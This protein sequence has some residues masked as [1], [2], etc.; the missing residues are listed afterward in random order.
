MSST[1]NYNCSDSI[2]LKSRALVLL[3]QAILFNVTYTSTNW[4][5]EYNQVEASFITSLDLMMPFIPWMILPYLS[6]AVFFLLAFYLCKHRR[7]FYQLNQSLLIATLV[8]GYFFYF[9]P[10]YFGPYATG[11]ATVIG[12]PWD[13]LFGMLRT[14]D[15]PYNQMPSLHIIYG[16]IL[17]F[18]LMQITKPITKVVVSVGIFTLLISTLLTHQ[19]RIIDVITGLVFAVVIL[20]FTKQCRFSAST[21]FYFGLSAACLLIGLL[22]LET[23]F[24]LFALLAYLSLGFAIVTLAYGQHNA[25]LLGKRQ[26]GKIHV[27]FWLI[28]FPYIAIYWLMWRIYSKQQK[29]QVF[30]WLKIGARPSNL[31]ALAGMTHII[32]LGAELPVKNNLSADIDYIGLPLLDL[33]PIKVNEALAFCEKLQMLKDG[34]EHLSLYLHCTMGISRSYAMLACYLAWSDFIPVAQIRSYI[35][36]IHPNAILRENYLRQEVLI[37]LAHLGAAYRSRST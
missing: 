24:Y 3:L 13:W 1:M 26:S 14:I 27:L 9:Y 16:V 5:A 30:S 12:Q 10:L 34:S 4:Y 7:N 8:A 20:R 18:S 17:W 36:S 31:S 28:N 11:T 29:R 19:H 15:K 35:F 33:D 6:S 22:F 2:S 21:L 25:K 23:H 37:E 32:D